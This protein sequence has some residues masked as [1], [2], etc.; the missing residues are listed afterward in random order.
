MARKELT[1]EKLALERS[2]AKLFKS[3]VFKLE[4]DNHN[5]IYAFRSTDGWWKVG[6]NSALFLK[7][8]VAKRLK[9]KYELRTDRDFYYNFRDG[10]IPIKN[11]E[12]LE[13]NLKQLRIFKKGVEL[14][15]VVFDIPFGPV[16][17]E[18][19]KEMRHME[20]TALR[21]LNKIIS[22][23]DLL[24]KTLP[25]ARIV[26]KS[27]FEACRKLDEPSRDLIGKEIVHLS[28]TMMDQIMCVCKGA[29][30]KDAIVSKVRGAVVQLNGR[31]TLLIDEKRVDLE[32]GVKLLKHLEFL[33]R[34]VIEECSV[35]KG[36][37]SNEKI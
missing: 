10:V 14:G 15:Y 26:Q 3:Q 13:E 27:L 7:Y 19:I 37:D 11:V 25:Q 34:I 1:K 32:S 23:G 16:S 24:V 17:D 29:V 30:P 31:V 21:E 22:P 6:G 5:H 33:E 12:K 28:N 18:Q 36:G 9:L 35:S 8:R 20:R 2:N 4:K